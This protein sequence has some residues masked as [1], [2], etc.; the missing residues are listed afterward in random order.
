MKLNLPAEVY[1]KQAQFSLEQTALFARTWQLLGLEKQIQSKGEY[2]SADL[3]GI[4]V[5]L[6]RDHEGEIKGY[7]NVCRH[8]GAQLLPQGA[9]RCKTIRCPYHHWVYSLDG[10]LI[11]TPWFGEDESFNP[12][13]WPLQEISV[14]SW[15][16]LLFACID[17]VES[18]QKQIAQT[19]NELADI[20]IEHLQ[21]THTETLSFTGNWKIYTD[22]FVEGYHIPG[23]HPD[24]FDAIDFEQFVTTAE[25]GFV[26]MTA[27]AKKD[28]F[29][30]GRWYWMWPNWTLSLFEGGMNTSRINPINERQTELHYQFYF[31]KDR[32]NDKKFQKETIASNLEVIRQDFQICLETHENYESGGYSPGP[33]STRQE[34]GVA[35]FQESYLQQVSR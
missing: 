27:P 7:R 9:G 1:V 3:A 6:I 5:F 21:L 15:R 24:F 2:L 25:D 22:N 31:D 35:Y 28:L 34:Q 16:G 12:K 33:L 8:R 26:K 17:P 20:D 30:K 4:K 19:S 29:Y 13:D 23:I 18:L 32:V 10:Q 14:E 11:N